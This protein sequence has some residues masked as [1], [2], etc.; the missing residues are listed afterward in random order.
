[1]NQCPVCWWHFVVCDAHI[2][3]CDCMVSRKHRL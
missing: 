1:M 2:W 3:T